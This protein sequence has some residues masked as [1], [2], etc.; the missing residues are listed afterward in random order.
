MG[1]SMHFGF[2]LVVLINV[3]KS[4]SSNTVAGFS[5]CTAKS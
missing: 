3:I 2:G 4:F 1:F 5:L